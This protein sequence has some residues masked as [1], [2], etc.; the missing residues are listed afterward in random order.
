M[1]VV[2]S[3]CI[4]C[5]TT[6]LSL[7]DLIRKAFVCDSEGNSYIRTYASSGASTAQ[8]CGLVED[9]VI[10]SRTINGEVHSGIAVTHSLNKTTGIFLSVTDNKGIT[11]IVSAQIIDANSIFIILDGMTDGAFC[12]S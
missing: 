2:F 6:H 7:E 9:Y 1:S 10:E 3:S 8:F 12:I 5:S 4:N 11:V